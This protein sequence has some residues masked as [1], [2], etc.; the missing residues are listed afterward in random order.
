MDN[1]VAK[2]L[3]S[4]LTIEP[5]MNAFSYDRS[6]LKTGIIHLGL[7]AFHRAHQ[8]LYTCE[9]LSAGDEKAWGICAANI[10]SNLKLVEALDQQD[11]L[12]SVTEVDAKGH[13]SVSICGALVKCL[14]ARVDPVPLIQQ[15]AELETRI[16]SLTIT[17]KGYCLD[18]SSDK[19]LTD[20]PDIQNDIH[21]PEHPVTAMGFIIQALKIRQQKSRPAFTVL[22]CDNI[23][24]NGQRT[25]SAVLQLAKLSDPELANWIEQNVAF[26]NTMVDRIVP[27][28]SDSDLADLAEQNSFY[29][30]AALLTENF[31]QWVVEDNFPMGRPDWDLIDGAKFVDDVRPYETMKLRMLN[32]C[33][34]FL[35]YLGYLGG[36][37]TIAQ[38]MSHSGY[39]LAARRLL[40]EEAMVSLSMPE[41]VDLHAYADQI[42]SRF[43]NTCLKHKTSQ[44]AMDG[45][46]KI[47]QR[48]LNTVRW[49]LKQKSSFNFLGLGIAAWIQY[50]S[51]QN[52]LGERIEVLDPLKHEFLKI[53]NRYPDDPDH[54]L[55]NML[56]LETVFGE[57]LIVN[58][59]FKKVISNAYHILLESGAEAAVISL[60]ERGSL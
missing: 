49:H 39:R 6:Q 28:V 24:E 48:W 57:D 12:F 50:A 59:E 18:P 34:S 5:W 42:L 41:G 47:P 26:P 51:G 22:S 30:S 43:S 7:G 25:R 38:V 10:R 58:T 36:F 20:H 11:N 33:H 16:V 3:N 54:F 29:D 53:H 45:S 19:L 21:H 35:A 1:S 37:Q 32:G 46:Q 23:P 17:E 56:N 55:A 60:A 13:R 14:F 31:R 44:V 4:D 40:Y 8:A 27:S 15:M 52:L 9:T 2:R